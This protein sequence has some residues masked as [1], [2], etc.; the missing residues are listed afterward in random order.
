[1]SHRKEKKP[2]YT[3]EMTK[4]RPL[5]ALQNFVVSPLDGSN[6]ERVVVYTIEESQRGVMTSRSEM[7]LH[8]SSRLVLTTMLRMQQ[9]QLTQTLNETPVDTRKLPM[10]YHTQQQ[11]Q[12]YYCY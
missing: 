12:Y 6:G 10:F 7:S 3:K 8:D 5:L 11:Q 9:E 4:R 1:M 2:E